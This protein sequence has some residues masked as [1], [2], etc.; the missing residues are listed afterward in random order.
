MLLGHILTNYLIVNNISYTNIIV[1]LKQQHHL[2]LYQYYDIMLY[3][4]IAPCMLSIDVLVFGMT[5]RV[6]FVVVTKTCFLNRNLN[7]L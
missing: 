4:Y 2:L 6:I 7:R 5:N 1:H 3:H